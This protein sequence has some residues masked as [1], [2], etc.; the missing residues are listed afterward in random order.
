MN[1]NWPASGRRERVEDRPD[2]RV[3]VGQDAEHSA[4]RGPVGG[5]VGGGADVLEEGEDVG[6][7]GVGGG[8]GEVGVECFCEVGWERW[9]RDLDGFDEG[10]FGGF[11]GRVGGGA[12]VGWGFGSG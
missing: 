9:T 3:G 7:E 6:V 10:P 1:R 2:A 8:G 12:G 4:A 5:A 11:A